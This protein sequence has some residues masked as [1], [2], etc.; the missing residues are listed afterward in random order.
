MT[1]ACLTLM[2]VVNEPQSPH[3]PAG[4]SHAKSPAPTLIHVTPAFPEFSR[5]PR[6]PFEKRSAHDDLEEFRRDVY[7]D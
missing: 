6:I 3:S 4:P 5:P 1:A 2:L 7:A